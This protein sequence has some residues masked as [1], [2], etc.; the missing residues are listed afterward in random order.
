MKRVIV[1]VAFLAICLSL[2][3]DV[4]HKKIE[5]TFKVEK[6]KELVVQN[7]Y[8]AIEIEQWDK[9]IIEIKVDIR[10]MLVTW[11]R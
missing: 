4:K 2:K 10:L 11:I 5:K 1:F 6:M 7:S 9:D 3:A 8:G